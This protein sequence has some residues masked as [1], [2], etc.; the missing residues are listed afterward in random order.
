MT[1]LASE[2]LRKQ[3]E[4]LDEEAS[5]LDRSA[6]L[7]IAGN[8]DRQIDLD[9]FRYRDKKERLRVQRPIL[10][11]KTL[12][13]ELPELKAQYEQAKLDSKVLEEE[14]KNA[15]E[16]WRLC[17]DAEALAAEQHMK[18]QIKAYGLDETIKETYENIATKR[19][20]LK[21]LIVEVVGL[22]PEVGPDGL[23]NTDNRL[24]RN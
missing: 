22:D 19:R 14:L 21:Q 11:S 2:E 1:D 15:A 23:S 24:I 13:A 17:R 18:L 9:L 20:R 4:A 16:Y 7:A 6:A 5:E 10:E 8:G 3:L 12:Q